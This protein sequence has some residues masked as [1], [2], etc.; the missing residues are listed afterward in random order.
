[1][2]EQWQEGAP[3]GREDRGSITHLAGVFSLLAARADEAV[4]QREELPQ[5]GLPQLLLALR[6]RHNGQLQ[7]LQDHLV[8]ALLACVH[9]GKIF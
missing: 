6:V 5:P 1:M 2:I 3:A 4:V 9:G 8:A 7:L